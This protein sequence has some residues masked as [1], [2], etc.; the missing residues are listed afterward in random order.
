MRQGC[1]LASSRKRK[2][3][4]RASTFLETASRDPGDK[5]SVS[6]RSRMY[7]MVFGTPKIRVNATN[8]LLQ[9]SRAKKDGSHPFGEEP[10]PFL[11]N[12]FQFHQESFVQFSG[13]SRSGPG[14]SMYNRPRDEAHGTN[15][16]LLG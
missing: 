15:P 10:S 6:A 12:T 4:R 3:L 8:R 9:S 14:R 2:V 7:P 11:L 5:G 1:F 13:D 16:A